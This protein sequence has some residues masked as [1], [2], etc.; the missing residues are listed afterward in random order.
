MWKQ[1]ASTADLIQHLRGENVLSG[2]DLRVQIHGR[3]LRPLI[4]WT[5]LLLG[6][7]VLLTRPDR[8]MFWVAAPACLSSPVLQASS[9]A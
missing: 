2:N 7:P 8:H 1:F 9:S 4:D 5:V 6:L 3:F